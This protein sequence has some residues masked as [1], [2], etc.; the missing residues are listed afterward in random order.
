MLLHQVC[1]IVERKHYE[2]KRTTFALSGVM[3][4]NYRSLPLQQVPG[5]LDKRMIQRTALPLCCLREHCDT[6]AA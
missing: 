3:V 1:Q 4:L 2:L 5:A 6:I